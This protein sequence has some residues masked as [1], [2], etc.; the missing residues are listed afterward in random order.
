[1]LGRGAGVVA[2]A[3]ERKVGAQRVEQRERL[4]RGGILSEQAVGAFAA[5]VGEFRRREMAREFE[6]RDPAQ[7]RAVA[8]IAHIGEGNLMP[9]MLHL[10]RDVK[11]AREES[12]QGR[13]EKSREGKAEFGTDKTQWAP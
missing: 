3:R 4:R 12:K 11:V 8:G 5:D 7:I 9:S 10:E 2:Q 6:R 13:W 1:M